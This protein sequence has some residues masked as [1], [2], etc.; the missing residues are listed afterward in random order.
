M[1]RRPEQLSMLTLMGQPEDRLHIVHEEWDYDGNC[2]LLTTEGDKW[3]EHNA[4]MAPKA[5]TRMGAA[6]MDTTS[7]PQMVAEEVEV[8]EGQT[9]NE[10]PFY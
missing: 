4:K 2:L 7:R 6:S 10:T 1:K 3:R 9:T 5:A 8:L